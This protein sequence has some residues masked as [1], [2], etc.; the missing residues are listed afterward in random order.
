MAKRLNMADLEKNL[1]SRLNGEGNIYTI[2]LKA[3]GL[4][5]QNDEVEFAN[6]FSLRRVA[7]SLLLCAGIFFPVYADSLPFRLR[8]RRPMKSFRK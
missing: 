7:A 3:L 5:A 2:P 4:N 8:R 1:H 6:L